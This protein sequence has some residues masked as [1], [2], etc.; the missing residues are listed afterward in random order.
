MRLNPTLPAE[1]RLWINID[2]GDED[3]CWP[4]IGHLEDGYGRLRVGPDGERM[5]AHRFAWELDNGPV[6]DG[7]VMDH[8]CRNRACCNPS[9]LEPVTNRKNLMRGNT[10]A[11][12]NAAKTHCKR[13]HE[14]NDENTY[15]DSQG[16]RNCRPCKQLSKKR[17]LTHCPQGHPYDEDNT[18]RDARGHRRCVT[19][20]PQK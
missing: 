12:R 13:G 19:C 17:N 6:P 18:Y 15:I 20:Y 8:L 11:A 10:R 2:Q 16:R 3:E 9:H 4:W 7:L 14:F 5:P 1:E